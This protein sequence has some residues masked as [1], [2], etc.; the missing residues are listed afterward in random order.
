MPRIPTV[1]SIHRR[2]ASPEAEFQHPV[3]GNRSV[4]RLYVIELTDGA[5]TRTDPHLPWVYVGQTTLTPE[6]R[7]EQHRSGARNAKGRRLHSKW[8]H[9]FGVRLRPDLYE[10][11]PVL[12][13]DD[14]ALE[15]EAALAQRLEL[16]GFS[17]RGG[18]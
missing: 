12:Y 14:E 7:F 17:V 11:E 6:Q 16:S 2:I 5:G 15:A 10:Q 3:N 1:F 9:R 18:H 4:W 13:R 8:P